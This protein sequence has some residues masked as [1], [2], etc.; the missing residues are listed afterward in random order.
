H[1]VH[2]GRKKYFWEVFVVLSAP[3]ARHREPPR[4]PSAAPQ[5]MPGGLRRGGRVCVLRGEESDTR[6]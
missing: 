4:P 1:E 5:A 6:I 3:H 2:E